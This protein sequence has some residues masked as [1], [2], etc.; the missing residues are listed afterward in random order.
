[1]K[2]YVGYL[3]HAALFV[4]LLH[5]GSYLNQS[6]RVA[7]GRTFNPTPVLVFYIV[8]PI[9]IGIYLAL[10]NFIIN[11]RRPGLWK[12]EWAKF[13]ILGTVSLFLALTPILSFLTPIGQRMPWLT[14]WLFNFNQGYTIAGT[15]FGYLLL[16]VPEKISSN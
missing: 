4:F 10:P 8:F 14:A 3:I 6:L 7:A 5:W 13:A 12:F 15:L 9:A 2:K 11:I 16:S 1:M